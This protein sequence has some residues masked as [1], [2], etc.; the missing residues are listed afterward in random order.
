MKPKSFRRQYRKWLVSLVSCF[1]IAWLTG[2]NTSPPVVDGPEVAQGS[3]QNPQLLNLDGLIGLNGKALFPTGG[4]N[5]VFDDF[6]ALGQ[7]DD[8]RASGGS[9]GLAVTSIPAYFGMPVSSSIGLPS[10]VASNIANLAATRGGIQRDVLIIVPDDYNGVTAIGRPGVFKLGRE[11]YTLGARVTSPTAEGRAIQIRDEIRRLEGLNELSHGAIVLNHLFAMLVKAGYSLEREDLTKPIKPVFVLKRTE[12]RQ[13]YV[14]PV[15]TE[16]LDTVMIRDSLRRAL[17]VLPGALGINQ[18]VV[19]MSYGIVSCPLQEDYAAN[20]K[21]FPTFESYAKAV[22]VANRSLRSSGESSDAFA[23]RV[24][25]RLTTPYPNDPLQQLMQMSGQ[26]V[27]IPNGGHLIY[28]AAAGNFGLGFSL[29]PAAWPDAIGVS[30]HDFKNSAT[31]PA[32]SNS[33]E[34]IIEGA[35]FRLTDPLGFAGRAGFV[36]PTIIYRGTSFASPQIAFFTALD[37]ADKSPACGYRKD[38][39]PTLIPKLAHGIDNNRLLP[40]LV[41]D[42]CVP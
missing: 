8:A 19:N 39:L 33:G 6:D 13:I 10:T 21:L 12:G 40:G 23:Q 5:C 20:Q 14:V 1:F 9:G 36:S 29:F 4:K 41:A 17:A 42:K 26:F 30:A 34:V 25:V 24:I 28:V 38:L 16:D 18:V 35:W 32:F 15:D 31:K 37:L 3:Q 22:A 7:A 2:C 11:V 27:N